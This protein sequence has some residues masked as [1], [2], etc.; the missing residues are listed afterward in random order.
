MI[1]IFVCPL[2]NFRESSESR[3]K[4]VISMFICGISL[5]VFN[6]I[7]HFFAALNQVIKL[8]MQREIQYLYAPMYY[9]LC[10]MHKTGNF[11]NK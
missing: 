3:L 5:L 11:F 8:N 10:S 2:D 6:F 4:V 7:S 9:P 1:K